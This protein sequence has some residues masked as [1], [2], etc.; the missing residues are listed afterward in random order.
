MNMVT[1]QVPDL[2]TVRDRFLKASENF[3][4]KLLSDAVP[5]IALKEPSMQPPTF[6][7]RPKT[8]AE[9]LRTGVAMAELRESLL[10]GD[11]GDQMRNESFRCKPSHRAL[12]P[13]LHS[14][15]CRLVCSLC[16]RLECRAG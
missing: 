10:S 12:L 14:S 2:E 6:D 11:G 9:A 13:L 4:K 7:R 5:L 16:V 1:A 15:L 8:A 3:N